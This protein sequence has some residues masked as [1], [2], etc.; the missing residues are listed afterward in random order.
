LGGGVDGGGGGEHSTDGTYPSEPA[1]G[2]PAEELDDM[3]GRW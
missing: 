2:E 3:I 1:L